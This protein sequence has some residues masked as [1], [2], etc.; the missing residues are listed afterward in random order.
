MIVAFLIAAA[1]LICIC[2]AG[3]VI[4]LLSYPYSRFEFLGIAMAVFGGALTATALFV[5]FVLWLVGI[6]TGA[7]F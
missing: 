2:L 3:V 1:V 4:G 6:A 7:V 5:A